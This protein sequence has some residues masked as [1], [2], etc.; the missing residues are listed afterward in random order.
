MFH[1]VPGAAL[2]APLAALCERQF[3]IHALHSCTNT[4]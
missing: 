1:A 3:A 4:K 2:L